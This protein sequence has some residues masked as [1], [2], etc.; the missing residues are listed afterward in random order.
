MGKVF[1]FFF[2]LR[3][4]GIARDADRQWAGVRGN[5]ISISVGVVEERKVIEATP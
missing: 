4:Y 2:F 1:P 3:D 5:F